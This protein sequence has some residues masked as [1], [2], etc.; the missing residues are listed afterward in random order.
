[1][2][3]ANNWPRTVFR[4]NQFDINDD[5]TTFD[6]SMVVESNNQTILTALTQLTGFIPE[7][8]NDLNNTV[9]A[10]GFNIE[11]GGLSPA[12]S[13]IWNELQQP[14]YNCPPLQKMQSAIKQNNPEVVFRGLI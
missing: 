5:Y 13:R 12:I 10:L 2:S 8:V 9:L 1:M 3:I 4:F 11:V 7:Y 6:M 14:S